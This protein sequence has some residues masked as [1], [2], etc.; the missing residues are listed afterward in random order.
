MKKIRLL[1]KHKF[2]DI[3]KLRAA[4]AISS[5]T[6]E[7]RKAKFDDSEIQTKSIRVLQVGVQ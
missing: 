2:N 3:P 5:S 4:N 6:R 1:F 7:V